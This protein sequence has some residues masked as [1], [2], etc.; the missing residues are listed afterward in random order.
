MFY[1]ATSPSQPHPLHHHRHTP[2]EP[3]NLSPEKFDI[4][5]A[6]RIGKTKKKKKRER[7]QKMTN[8]Q[9]NKRNTE[10]R[11]GHRKQFLRFFFFHSPIKKKLFCV[12][13]FL[14]SSSDFC[15]GPTYG[16]DARSSRQRRRQPLAKQKKTKSE[17]KQKKKEMFVFL[18]F[19]RF[20]FFSVSSRFHAKRVGLVL[21][22]VFFY[23]F[24]SNFANRFVGLQPRPQPALSPA[25][26]PAPSPPSRAMQLVFSKRKIA[27]IPLPHPQPLLLIGRLCF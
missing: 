27:S 5:V 7:N 13:L 11:D 24:F 2:P 15:F 1:E 3:A 14:G 8:K 19:R 17:T 22:V 4:R 6:K 16:M 10:R 23:I 21:C 25:L 12:F 18:S 20:F 26:S 9:A